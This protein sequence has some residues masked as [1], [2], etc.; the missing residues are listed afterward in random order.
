MAQCGVG[1]VAAKIMTTTDGMVLDSFVIQDRNGCA[2]ES[3]A[4]LEELAGRIEAALDAPLGPDAAPAPRTRPPSSTAA[5]EVV[6]RVLIDNQA[7]GLHTVVEINAR[8]RPGLLHDVTRALA[9]LG[10]GIASAHIQTFG[11]RAVDVFYLKNQFGLKIEKAGQL[12]ALTARLTEVLDP[13]EAPASGRAAAPAKPK[14][15]RAA[16]TGKTRA[17]PRAKGAAKAPR[18]RKAAARAG[19]GSTSERR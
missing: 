19:A 7:S 1:I 8:D 2:V 4:R 16:A 11:E 17:R 13:A 18:R 14:R 15:R 3:E 12:D 6:P 10:L 9:E 5:F